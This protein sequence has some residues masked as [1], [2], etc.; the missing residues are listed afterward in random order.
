MQFLG[1]TKL[2]KVIPIMTATQLFWGV[3]TIQ[4]FKNKKKKNLLFDL[5]ACLH[6]DKVL[7]ITSTFNLFIG[8]LEDITLGQ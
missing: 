5:G 3:I 7:S 8:V 2:R 4:P 1:F 6:A